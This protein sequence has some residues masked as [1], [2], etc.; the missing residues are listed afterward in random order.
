MSEMV[1]RPTLKWVRFAYTVWFLFAFV[2]VLVCNNYWQGKHLE[3]VALAVGIVWAVW[4]L[5]LQIRRRMTKLI[6]EDDKLRLE[7]GL[8]SKTT[9]TLQLSKI[10]DIT[11]KQSPLQRL[12]QLGDLSLETAGESGP[13]LVRNLDQPQ[14]LADQIMDLARGQQPPAKR[15][16]SKN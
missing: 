2:L 16:E 9:R 12:L 15:K 6:V 5:R 1:V 8:L 11:V 7:V 4:P 13:L 10:Q 3:W 14:A